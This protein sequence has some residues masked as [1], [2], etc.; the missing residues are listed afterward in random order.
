M[1]ELFKNNKIKINYNVGDKTWFG[2]G[3]NCFCFINVNSR[4]ILSFILNYL[5]KFFPIFVLGNG[6]NIIVR[7]GG[8]NGIVIKLGKEF[9]NISFNK[10][11]LLMTIG[12]SAKDTEI[13]SFCLKNGI[14]GFEFLVGIPGTLGGNLKMNSGCYGH[15]ISDNFIDCKIMNKFGKIVTLSEKQM[16][17]SYRNSSITNEIIL[18]ANFK[19]QLKN[20]NKIKKKMDLYSKIR[21]KNQ[22]TALRTGGS[23][24][25]NPTKKSAWKLID[26]VNFRGKVLGGAKVSELHSNFFIN[27]KSA[28]SLELEL[29]GEEIRDKVWNKF[30]IK[31][32]WEIIRIGKFKQI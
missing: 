19:V 3:G 9:S 1:F 15:E 11:K 12:S 28:T 32:E 10:E 23:T 14:A 26:A 20:K 18:E 4:A 30:K 8:I 31:L 21:K 17:F 27:N 13:S 24:F 16:E 29:L 7:D 6:S 25:A 5:G 22:P 2:S